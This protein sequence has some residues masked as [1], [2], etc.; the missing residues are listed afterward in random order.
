MAGRLETV[1]LEKEGDLNRWVD[2]QRD[3]IVFLADL[4]QMRRDAALLTEDGSHEARARIGALLLSAIGSRSDLEELCL[5]SPVGGEVLVSTNENHL[6]GYRTSE[7]FYTRG[8]MATFVQNVYMSPITGRPGVTIATPVK[9]DAER[10][11]AVVAGELDLAYIDRLTANRTGLGRTGEAYLV[12]PFNDFV[13]SV[14][15][16]RDEFRR[17]VFSAGNRCSPF[18]R[19]RGRRLRKLRRD[20][21]DRRLPVERRARARA[22]RR[23]GTGGGV[24]ARTSAGRDHSRDRPVLGAHARGRRVFHCSANCASRPRDCQGGDSGRRWRFHHRGSGTDVGRG[25]GAR[26]RLQRHDRTAAP[27]LCRPQRARGSDEP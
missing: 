9:D 6:G 15:F 12:S 17:G 18:G 11:I 20:P 13:S 3:L 19:A 23:N 4:P 8:K 24:C 5:L 26:H 2:Q 21:G 10:T 25:G 1:A 27:S 14:R 7:L 16:G 22:S